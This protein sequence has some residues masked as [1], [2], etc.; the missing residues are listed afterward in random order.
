MHV[1]RQRRDEFKQKS[2]N[3][4]PAFNQTTTRKLN[5]NVEHLTSLRNA[6]KSVRETF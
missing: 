3:M 6:N 1:K 5:A 2:F 4:F